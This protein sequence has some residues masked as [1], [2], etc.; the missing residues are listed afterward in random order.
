MTEEEVTSE[1]RG[2]CVATRQAGVVLYGIARGRLNVPN[3]HA[4]LRNFVPD[5]TPL[6][7]L[8][9]LPSLHRHRKAMTASSTSS[10]AWRA[11]R[12]A[13]CRGRLQALVSFVLYDAGLG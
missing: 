8:F 1:T 4:S 11:L 9:A 13:L 6:Q 7:A 10:L 12:S 5:Q 3:T 2:Q